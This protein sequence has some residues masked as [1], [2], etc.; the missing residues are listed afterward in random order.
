MRRRKEL[1]KIL[2][3]SFHDL[4]LLKH[5]LCHRSVGKKSNERLEFLGDAILN[6]VI[7]A[8]LFQK[9]P[10]MKEGDLSRLRANLVN[11]DV[12]AEL[13][14]EFKLGEYLQ[15]GVGELRSGGAKRNSILADA[16]EA[17]IGAIYLDGGFPEVRNCVV[18]WFAKLLQA[19][20]GVA[21]KDP[22]TILQELLQMQKLPLPVYTVV[23]TT[24]SSHAQVFTV[25]C[26]VTGV[27]SK[28][29]G[30]G[31]NKRRAE[32]SA[33]EKMLKAIKKL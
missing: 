10:N 3:Y 21:K 27:T 6:F 30:V 19:S 31:P 33:A 24:G 25:E 12:L 29:T 13:A 20:A 7:A 2:G 14:R 18:N 15:F 26:Q 4:G 32:R 28:T 8:E 1:C 9:Y 17:V 11:G 22:K 23:T 5:A 16:M